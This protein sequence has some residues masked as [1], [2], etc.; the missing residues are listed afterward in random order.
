[1]EVVGGKAG[2]QRVVVIGL[3]MVDGLHGAQTTSLTKQFHA[4]RE[5]PPQGQPAAMHARLDGPE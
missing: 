1:M 2:D 5:Q 3:A 4:I